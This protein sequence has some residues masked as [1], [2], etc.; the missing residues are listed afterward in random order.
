VHR[1]EEIAGVLQGQHVLGRGQRMGTEAD[2]LVDD[3]PEPLQRVARSHAP[4][5]RRGCDNNGP[6]SR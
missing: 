2:Q 5:L 3:G 4:I 1:L 6:H